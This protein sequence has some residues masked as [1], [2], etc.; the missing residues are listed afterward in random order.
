MTIPPDIPGV[1]FPAG[2]ASAADAPKG[3]GLEEE[4]VALFDQ[5]RPRLVQYSLGFG[6]G[7]S[8][9]EEIVQDAFLAL[10]QHLVR[11]KSRASLR[12]WLFQVTHNLSLKRRLA[13]WRMPLEPP[14]SGDEPVQAVDPYPNPEDQLAVR[15][16]RDRLRA[17]YA[18]L[19]ETD[20]Q[21]LYFRAEG[22]RYREIAEVL[23]ISLGSVANSLARSVSRLAAV[24]ER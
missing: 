3:S 22:L 21:C 12:A 1:P 19:P 14:P 4:I 11:G 7:V 16:R 8:D 24:D 23:G 18:A 15:Q 13:L 2:I 5:M 6:V 20:R 9:A 17:V 10:Y